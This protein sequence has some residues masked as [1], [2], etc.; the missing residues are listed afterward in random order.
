VH[1]AVQLLKL[2]QVHLD[3]GVDVRAGWQQRLQLEVAAVVGIVPLG[4][5]VAAVLAVA[6]KDGAQPL[7]RVVADAREQAEELPEA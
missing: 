4:A 2:A 3:E 1:D 7:V 6:E 5:V